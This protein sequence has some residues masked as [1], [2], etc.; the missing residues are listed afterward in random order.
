MRGVSGAA[1]PTTSARAPPRPTGRDV[2]LIL[3]DDREVLLAF[4]GFPAEP[5]VYQRTTNP[6][7]SIFASPPLRDPRHPACADLHAG[8]LRREAVV[9][10]PRPRAPGK[11][12][13]GAKYTDGLEVADSRKEGRLNR[14]TQIGFDGLRSL[15]YKF[16]TG[17][18]NGSEFQ[19][20]RKT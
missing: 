12:I 4:Y 14:A 11:V 15:V 18:Y 19:I 20:G 7:G 5:R 9:Q 13:M 6:I 16:R 10:N 3:A 1:Y 8:K 2:R 17:R